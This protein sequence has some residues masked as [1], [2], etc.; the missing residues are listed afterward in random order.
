MPHR[1]S[2]TSEPAPAPEPTG[3]QCDRDV[4]AFVA[5]ILADAP[6]EPLPAPIE[7]LAG[8]EGLGIAFEPGE[9]ERLG[10]FLAL[11]LHANT[12]M[13]LTA[14]KDPAQAWQRHI[15]DSLTLMAPLAELPQG[16]GVVDIGT[17]GGVPGIPLAIVRPD[18]RFTLLDATAK[19]T[20][21]VRAAL[22][23]VGVQQATVVTAR[24]EQAARDTQHRDTYDAAI[25][26]AVGP[27]ATVAE[28]VTPFVKP[29]G[30]ALLIKGEKAGEELE[31]AKAALHLLLCAH[32]GTIE[33]P[34]GRIVVL[35]KLR[36]TPKSYPRG[37]GEPKRKPLGRER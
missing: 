21:F 36:A 2:A 6:K 16:A 31:S 12:R 28:L 1:S 18:L 9:V 29:G 30:V 13:N 27:M 20:A 3:D 10:R 15:L 7:F 37:N 34:T 35:E 24:A 25:A 33:T 8:A 22:D 5:E 4:A 17:G 14:I 32:A 23:M 11:L 26:R 19:K